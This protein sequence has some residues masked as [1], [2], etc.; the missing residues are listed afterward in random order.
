MNADSC[1]DFNGNDFEGNLMSSLTAC[2]ECTCSVT[3]SHSCGDGRRRLSTIVVNTNITF[4]SQALY[5]Q[6]KS[7]LTNL[8]SSPEVAT[9]VLKVEVTDIDD[10]EVIF[11]GQASPPTSPPPT[12]P[13]NVIQVSPPPASPPSSPDSLDGLGDNQ[14]VNTNDDDS[15]LVGPIVGGV[16][17]GLAL[18]V[19]LLF[20]FIKKRDRGKKSPT[21]KGAED[22]N[23]GS[24]DVSDEHE[25]A[26]PQPMAVSEA[27]AD[28][29]TSGQVIPTQKE[30]L[31]SA[32]N[33]AEGKGIKQEF[34]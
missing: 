7:F 31:S 1:D 34:V 5:D 8:T 28:A 24:A 23:Q 21:L 3:S 11:Y 18:L 22:Q 2:E 29:D 26:A 13:D 14:E 17:G 19:L 12:S 20:I 4:T 33:S 9:A 30:W 27:T 10:T 15:S 16:V 25:A 32:V 6:S